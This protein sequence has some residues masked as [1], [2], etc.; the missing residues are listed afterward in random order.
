MTVVDFIF[1]YVPYRT[2][3]YFKSLNVDDYRSR[4]KGFLIVIALFQLSPIYVVLLE[5]DLYVRSSNFDEKIKIGILV[6]SL[7]VIFGILVNYYDAKLKNMIKNYDEMD[8]EKHRKLT[9]FYFLYFFQIFVL[10][11][12]SCLFLI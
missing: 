12:L 7:Y 9:K 11:V 10:F 3:T 6:I 8:Q 2:Y 4:T 1:K 5:T